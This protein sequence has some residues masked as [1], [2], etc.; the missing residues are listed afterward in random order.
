MTKFT[1]GF[2]LLALAC[3]GS[4]SAAPTDSLYARLG[5]AEGVREIA[6]TLIDRVVADPLTAPSFQDVKLARLKR[7]LT[8]QLCDLAGGPCHYSGDSMREVHAGLN[9][10]Q[11][12][13]Y[14]MVQTLRTILDERHVDP[15]STN[16]L[17]RLLAPM[18]RDVVEQR[19]HAVSD[20]H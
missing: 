18:K 2:M 12:Q 16:E 3:G 9:I 14:D 5:G 6:G 7:L 1:F 17:L 8:E 15:R 4:A 10:S 20:S 13:F 11:A 19:T